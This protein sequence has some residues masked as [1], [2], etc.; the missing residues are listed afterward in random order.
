MTTQEMQE[1]IIIAAMQ[2]YDAARKEE[3]IQRQAKERFGLIVKE[4]LEV[5]SDKAI[6]KDGETGLV[7]Y[8][9]RRANESFDMVHMPNALVLWAKEHGLLKLDGK[10]FD[11]LKGKFGE[12]LDINQYRQEGETLVLQVQKEK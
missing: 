7:A 10:A 6:L 8:L 1:R 11:A 4:W 3:R 5:Q 12:A 9:Q 2:A